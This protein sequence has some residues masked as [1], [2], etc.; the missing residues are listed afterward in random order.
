MN[1]EFGIACTIFSSIGS[2]FGTLIIQK[3]IKKYQRF[4]I[5]I[6]ILGSVLGISTLMIPIHTL[7]N[8][9]K[10]VQ[11]GKNIWTFSNPC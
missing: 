1:L 10:D 5:L 4:S 3:L 7:I 2:F 8:I 9:I 11:D 6:L